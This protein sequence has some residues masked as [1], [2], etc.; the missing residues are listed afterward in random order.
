MPGIIFLS[1]VINKLVNK[2]EVI[3]N[4]DSELNE[5][6]MIEKILPGFNCGTCGYK[7]C[8]EYASTIYK[9]NVE[10]NLCRAGNSQ[11]AKNLRRVQ[12]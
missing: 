2:D 3:K 6:I 10:I 7:N 4:N 1:Y 5:I 9:K 11:I 8:R 12:Y